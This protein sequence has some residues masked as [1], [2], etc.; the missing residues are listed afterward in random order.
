MASTDKETAERAAA[1]L[2]YGIWNPYAGETPPA[3]TP[4]RDALFLIAGYALF[5]AKVAALVSHL[6]I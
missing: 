4:V 1:R 5:F 6:F 2:A 3:P